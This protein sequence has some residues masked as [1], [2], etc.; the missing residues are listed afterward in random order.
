MDQVG[1]YRDQVSFRF[2]G[3]RYAEQPARFTYSSIYDGN[4]NQT[5]LAPGNPCIQLP[6]LGNEDCLF[7]NIFTSYLPGHG[8][9]PEKSGLRPVVFYIH[10]GGFI[11]DRGSNPEYDGSNLASRGDVVVVTFDYRLGVFGFLALDDGI[12]HGNYGIGDQIIA[13][14]WVRTHIA[15]FGGDPDHITIMGQS[16]GAISVT[17]LLGSPKAIGKYVAAISMSIVNGPGEYG[18]YQNHLSLEEAAAMMI[19]SVLNPTNCTSAASQRDCLI[20]INAD[21]LL[22]DTSSIIP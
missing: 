13:L 9:T 14:D 22:S 19:T 18:I 5:A 15:N 21:Q 1:R 4:V 3:I 12:T 2:L 17:T 16:A 11:F 6:G 10:G 8:R 20:R 7:L